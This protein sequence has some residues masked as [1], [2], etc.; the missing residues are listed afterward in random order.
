LIS[1]PDAPDRSKLNNRGALGI[2]FIRMTNRPARMKKAIPRGA[3]EKPNK[4]YL[5][6][7]VQPLNVQI[8]VGERI[9]MTTPAVIRIRI[10]RR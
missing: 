9:E 6:A 5:W 10:K 7:S 2:R 1:A 8:S 3:K 4:R